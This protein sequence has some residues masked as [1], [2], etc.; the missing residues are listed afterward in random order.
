MCAAQR[1]F[2]LL[3]LSLALL[4]IALLAGAVLGTQTLIRQSEL[5]NMIGEY[6]SYQKAIG[7]FQ[8]KYLALPGDMLNATTTWGT[9]SGDGGCP[10]NSY[11]ATVQIATCNGDGNGRIGVSTTVGV[12]STPTEWWRAWQ[13]MANAGMIDGRFT[14]RRGSA[15][16]DHAVIGTNA[17]ASKLSPGGWTLLFYLQTATD[18]NLWGDSYGHI[19]QFGAATASSFTRGPIFTPSDALEV[20]TKIDDGMPGTGKMRSWR[21]GISN[22]CTT[23]TT[24]QTTTTYN[25]SHTEAA[26]APFFILSY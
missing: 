22:N 4:I 3:E 9:D 10:N 5:R 8:D 26:C 20:D 15:A 11:S 6:G 19:L 7:E 12:L 25:I 14:G 21:A 24:V 13:H 2:T 23:D 1:G 16:T 17:P 18:A